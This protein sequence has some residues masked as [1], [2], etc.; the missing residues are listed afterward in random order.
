MPSLQTKVE[1]AVLRAALSLPEPLQ[2]ALLRRPVVVDGQRLATETQLVLRMQQL[3]RQP[4]LGQRPLRESRDIV[5]T[6]GRM[7]AGRQP[8]GA[9]RDLTVDGA[10]GPI[11][12][13]LYT[14]SSRLGAD[15][16]PTMMFIH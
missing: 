10:D 7:V 16:V 15:P 1:T 14:P 12:A 5:V 3:T 8:V 13:R 4:S 11:A 9:I 6:Q 2:R